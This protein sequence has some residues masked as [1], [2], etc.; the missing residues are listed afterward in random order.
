MEATGTATAQEAQKKPQGVDLNVTYH[1]IPIKVEVGTDEGGNAIEQ[2]FRHRFAPQDRGDVINLLSAACIER[3]V[4]AGGSN[5]QKVE[6]GKS[7]TT[8]K[9]WR[10]YNQGVKDYPGAPDWR[11]VPADKQNDWHPTH[12]TIAVNELVKCEARVIGS[13]L[14]FDGGIWRV[15]VAVPSFARPAFT[16][17]FHV[18]EWGE[19]HA[20][21]ITDNGVVFSK[22]SNDQ[23]TGVNVALYIQTLLDLTR[24][25]DGCHIDGADWDGF[26][27]SE[28]AKNEF[29][30]KI[31]PAWVFRAADTLFTRW[32][33]PKQD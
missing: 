28:A 12:Q 10:K 24:R 11:E 18:N 20:S 14:T 32:Q 8:R 13:E 3:N 7:E 21:A 4:K 25:V 16:L 33:V 6:Y 2:T 19:K 27:T 31:Y 23:E 1:D 26:A 17:I 5:R 15:A 29:L 30:R 9:F 22:S